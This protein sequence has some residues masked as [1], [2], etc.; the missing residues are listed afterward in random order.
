MDTTAP[1]ALH[2]IIPTIAPFGECTADAV[3][4]W[5]TRYWD[6]KPFTTH[7][8]CP[9]HPGDAEAAAQATFLDTER[10]PDLIGGPTG[11]G[12][13]CGTVRWDSRED[14]TVYAHPADT[15]DLPQ[16][17]G[18]R[19]PLPASA[20]STQWCGSACQQDCADSEAENLADTWPAD[21][22]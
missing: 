22:S 7:F 14:Y 11:T 8:A 12:L 20:A 3:H 5:Q 9:A 2:S 10:G 15:T 21:A 16:C 19:M 17:Q 6:G 18:C 4:T 13:R 1:P